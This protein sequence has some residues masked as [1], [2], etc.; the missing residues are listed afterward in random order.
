MCFAAF[1]K[2]TAVCRRVSPQRAHTEAV[3]C[4]L[5]PEIAAPAPLQTQDGSAVAKRTQR[6]FFCFSFLGPVAADCAETFLFMQ[7]RSTNTKQNTRR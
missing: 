5:S 2:L 3:F 4:L 6:L 7:R 1:A